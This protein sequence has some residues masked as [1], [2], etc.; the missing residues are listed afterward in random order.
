M[1]DFAELKKFLLAEYKLTPREYKH[2][3]VSA[4]KNTD[5]THILFSS[6]LRNLL[7]YYL[8]SRKVNDFDSLCDLLVSDRLKEALPQGPLNYVLSL[9]GD[10]WFLPEKVASLADT[11]FN[12]RFVLYPQKS[13]G[14]AYPRVATV[15]A[16]MSKPNYSGHQNFRGSYNPQWRGSGRPS[17]PVKRCFE[18]NGLGHIARECTAHSRG[19]NHPGRGPYNRGNERSSAAAAVARKASDG[20]WRNANARV[21]TCSVAG[22]PELYK[23]EI[24]TQ[25]E[26]D[27]QSVTM[28]F[29]AQN[30]WE[31]GQFPSVNAVS[32][33]QPVSFCVYPLQCVDVFVDD[34]ACVAL[35]RLGMSNSDRE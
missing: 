20:N 35:K 10:D 23:R 25:C 3:F 8:D 1:G 2:R 13:Q 32:T 12:N 29:V 7:T 14:R 17:S 30:E 6:R 27:E 4:T 18:C 34:Q 33:K 19:Y 21:N 26:N 16:S 15:A 5:E 11:F 28:N 31:F 9:E 22:S 24:G